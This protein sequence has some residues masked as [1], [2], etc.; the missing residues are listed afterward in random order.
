MAKAKKA[1]HREPAPDE[2]LTKERLAAIEA[3]R[4]AQ[5]P[6][7]LRLRTLR[8]QH[9]LTQTELGDRVGIS[10]KYVS[11]LECGRKSPSWETLVALARFGFGMPLSVML[12]GVDAPIDGDVARL[13]ALLA[14]HPK[15]VQTNV[16][17][18][19]QHML[20]ALGPTA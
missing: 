16:L 9:N 10:Q 19:L 12:F 17:T 5:I 2:V 15:D 4:A 18:A 1:K 14:G 11:E 20:R 7:G 3:G 6:F 8:N 13:E